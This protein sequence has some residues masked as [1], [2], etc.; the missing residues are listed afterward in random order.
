V[1]T[2]QLKDCFFAP[3]PS[4]CHVAECNPSS[5][6]CEPIVGNEGKSCIDSN[7]LCTEGKLCNNGSCVGGTPKSCSH[8]TLGCYNGL[9]DT[10]SGNC[11]AD[12]IPP[13]GACLEAADDCNAGVCDAMG[14]CKPTP[15]NEGGNCED[16][17]PCTG[18]ETCTMGTCG[19]GQ[20]VSQLIHFSEDFADNSAGWQLGTEWQIG[21]ATSSTGHNYGGADPETD[22]SVTMDDGV[23]GTSLGGNVSTGIHNY[24]YLTSP[25]YDTS[26]TLGAIWLGYRRWL[27]SDHLPYMQNIVE[28]YDG[29]N[30]VVLWQSG[31]SPGVQDASWSPQVHELTAYKGAQMRLRFG[32]K[33]IKSGAYTVSG[34]NLD[35]IVI[36]NVV[37][38]P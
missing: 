37:C 7:D 11:Y 31:N 24:H 6:L 19:G 22:F 35:D 9:C 8:L 18:G 30:W 2:G 12:P 1:C 13:G 36:A 15:A 34:W 25:V 32:H 28:V 20:Q 33:V 38:I 26:Q 3:V 23:A 17:N 21:A 10:S 14:K 16:G 27:N 5:G 29:T 4:D